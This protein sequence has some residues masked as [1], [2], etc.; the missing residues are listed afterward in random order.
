MSVDVVVVVPASSLVL[1]AVGGCVWA[2][3]SSASV[4]SSSST[5]DWLA[6]IIWSEPTA[7]LTARRNCTRVYVALSNRCKHVSMRLSFIKLRRFLARLM[8]NPVVTLDTSV[9]LSMV[10]CC[11]C[12][13]KANKLGWG[14]LI[15]RRREA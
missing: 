2:L 10:V 6:L 1:A 11:K 12:P 8:G 9:W 7:W 15:R 4:S 5:S 3:S 14:T 13:R